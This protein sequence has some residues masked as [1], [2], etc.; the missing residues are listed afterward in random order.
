MTGMHVAVG[1]LFP[2]ADDG[3]REWGVLILPEIVVVSL[4]HRLRGLRHALV[5]QS[6]G[7]LGHQHLRHICIYT[8]F[9]L[10]LIHI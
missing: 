1:P 8:E 6:L 7:H 2:P 5:Q 10:S 4:A 3:S 9:T